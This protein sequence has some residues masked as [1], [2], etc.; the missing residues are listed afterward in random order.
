MTVDPS[1]IGILDTWPSPKPFKSAGQ[2]PIE[3]N[4][5]KSTPTH[6]KNPPVPL[7]K[8]HPSFMKLF[9]EFF[10]GV[11]LGGIISRGSR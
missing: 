10:S 1:K 4:P 2:E 3:A 8:I 7:K 6:K 5:K 11:L 9:R